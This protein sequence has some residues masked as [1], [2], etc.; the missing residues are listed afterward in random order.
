MQIGL[1]TV[2]PNLQKYINRSFTL[3][4]FRRIAELLNE[5]NIKLH[6]DVIMGLPDDT[7]EYF[8]KTIDY[9]LELK[10]YSIQVK[11]FY[12]NPETLFHEQREK[13][14]IKTQD[15]RGGFFVPYVREARGGIGERYFR[16]ASRYAEEKIK[17]F[18]AIKWKLVTF[19]AY[20]MSEGWWSFL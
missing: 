18:P 16:E 6:L 3:D 7:I 12:L 17:E 8:K 1:Q 10:P 14:E 15:R 5:N 20:Y 13:Y 11:Q 4:N 2:N 9:A 19:D